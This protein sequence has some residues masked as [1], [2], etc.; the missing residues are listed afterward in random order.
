VAYPF[1]YGLSYSSFEFSN[2]NISSNNISKDDRLQV[3]VDVTNIGKM[4]GE[5]V[6]QLYIGFKNSAVDRP[7]KLLRGFD[8]INFLIKETKT[9]TLEIEAQDLAWYNPDTHQW[10]IESMEYELYVGNSAA[11]KDL[12]MG[13]FTID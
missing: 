4:S 8:K 9:V 6:I 12:L 7:I 10:E 2:L 1:G 13:H 5:E 11:E 3:N